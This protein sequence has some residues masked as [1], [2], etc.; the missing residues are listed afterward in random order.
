MAG[1][2]TFD[3]YDNA[4]SLF[5]NLLL[6]PQGGFHRRPGT[7][8]IAEVKDSASPVVLAPFEF[9]IT[10]TYALEI[11]NKYMRFFRNQ[12]QLV[13]PNIS[14]TT[15]TNGTFDAGI[16]GWTNKSAGTGSISWASPPGALSLNSNGSG[17]EGIAEQA[18]TTTATGVSHVIRFEILGVPGDVVRF[19]AGSTSGAS[20]FAGV[21]RRVGV[22]TVAF[23]PTVSPFYIQFES[24]LSVSVQIDNVEFLDNQPLELQTPYDSTT[25]SEVLY[26]IKYTQSADTMYLT[27]PTYA[28]RKLLRLGTTMWSLETIAFRNGPYLNE[29]TSTVTMTLGATSGITTV[30][31]SG[32]GGTEFSSGFMATDVGRLLRIHDGTDWNWVR[33]RSITSATVA[34]VGVLGHTAHGVAATTRWALGLFSDTTGWPGAVGFFEERLGLAGVPS[35]P[36]RLDLSVTADFET[37]SPSEDDES[38]VDDNAISIAIASEQVNYIRWL[39]S[40]AK[41]VVG[42]SGSE[43]VADSTGASLTPADISLRQHTA[44]GSADITP[45]KINNRVLFVQRAGKKLRDFHFVLEQESYD[46]SDATILADHVLT[47][48]ALQMAYQESPD[49]HAWVVRKDGQVAVMVYEPGQQVIGWSRQIFGGSF[50]SGHAVCESVSTIPGQDAAGQ[51]FPSDDRDEVWVI[52]KRTINGVTRRYVEV[53]EGAFVG[54]RREDYTTE[55]LW[56]ADVL[57]EQGNAFYVDSGLTYSGIATSVI[58]GLAHLE[59]ETVQVWAEGARHPDIIVVSGAVTLDYAVTKA[60]IGLP[61]TWCYG[62]LKLPFGQSVTGSSPVI[63]LKQI[64]RVGFV[65]MDATPFQHGASKERLTTVEFRTIRDEVDS[66]VPLFTGE[67]DQAFLGGWETDPRIYLTGD[68]PG[69]FTCLAIVVEISTNDFK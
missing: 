56:K 11:G 34:T 10:Q 60:Q 64:P 21:S 24:P 12:A 32:V 51:V 63:K 54:P 28:T 53:L 50:G 7:R 17:N 13:T 1:R 5:Q 22:H 6:L 23:T 67:I 35:A 45:L 39:A 15:I 40:T 3:Q 38:V 58:S 31:A 8:F 33:I 43:F 29:N 16:T 9:S 47:S 59:G 37:F 26:Q 44:H 61:I 65:L 66:G 48:Q 19:R 18:V 52:V 20:D 69:P 68:G 36:Q 55:A 42:T 4:G 30:T 62:S 27:H 41:L 14:G 25:S 49:S 57:A 46:A 2:V